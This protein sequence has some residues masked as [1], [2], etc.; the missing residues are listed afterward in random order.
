MVVSLSLCS[1]CSLQRRY[2]KM[3]EVAPAPFLP[4]ALRAKLTAAACAL[5]TSV[6]LL[7]AATVEFLVE[8]PMHDESEFAF[9]EVNPRLQVRDREKGCVSVGLLLGGRLWSRSFIVLGLGT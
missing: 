8:D 7:G 4:P 9:I 1:D 5:G 2:Q 6:R 3:V